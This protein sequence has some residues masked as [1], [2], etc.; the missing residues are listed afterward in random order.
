MTNKPTLASPASIVSSRSMTC[1]AACRS[2]P[3]TLRQIRYAQR[4]LDA[5]PRLV[6]WAELSVAGHLIGE[7]MPIPDSGLLDALARLAPRHRECTVSHAVDAAV[8]TRTLGFAT[9]LSP[10]PLA[11]HISDAING[12]VVDNRSICAAQDC[13]RWCVTEGAAAPDPRL[14]LHGV[15][16]PST[17][18]SA[19]GC[20]VDDAS[21]S[22]RFIALLADFVDDTWPIRQLVGSGDDR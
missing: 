18:E 15:D 14:L 10:G 1:G 8:A 9:R 16:R 2:A 17:L 6:V 19:V 13:R 4:E 5:E 7:P 12:W 21:W 20:S 3:C 11:V 22:D